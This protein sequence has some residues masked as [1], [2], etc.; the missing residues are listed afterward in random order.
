MVD[1]FGRDE[2]ARFGGLLDSLD[3]GLV[4]MDPGHDFAHVNQAAAALLGFPAGVTT[5]SAVTTH[6][7]ELA[8]R[9]LNP[10]VNAVRRHQVKVRVRFASNR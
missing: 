7:M 4:S 8:R 6:M 1:D 2:I 3:L 10:V 5:T 9:S